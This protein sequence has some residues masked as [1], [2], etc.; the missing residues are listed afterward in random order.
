MTVGRIRQKH[1]TNYPLTGDDWTENGNLL[2]CYVRRFSDNNEH[3][4]GCSTAYEDWDAT[5]W[6]LITRWDWN[7]KTDDTTY[8]IILGMR[9]ECE[10]KKDGDNQPY[11][12]ILL[13]NT[14]EDSSYD[15]QSN[16]KTFEL[17][18]DSLTNS[19]TSYAERV[20]TWNMWDRVDR[21]TA[22]QYQPG[23]QERYKFDIVATGNGWIKNM[24]VD[25]YYFDR[26]YMFTSY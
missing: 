18:S 15:Y 21:A 8:N 16:N 19:G 6:E 24:T 25:V 17:M 23:E 3:K 12:R 9:F 22:R 5:N 11:A 14:G 7:F 4:F 2:R 13:T 20:V 10:M 26:G 1:D